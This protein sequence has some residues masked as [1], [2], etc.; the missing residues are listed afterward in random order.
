MGDPPGSP[1]L[2]AA[3]VP[4]MVSCVEFTPGRRTA[5][6]PCE[7]EARVLSCC[8]T[9]AVPTASRRHSPPYVPLGVRVSRLRCNGVVPTATA[10]VWQQFGSS[11]VCVC[12]MWQLLWF[13]WWMRWS[14]MR[15]CVCAGQPREFLLPAVAFSISLGVIT[16]RLT[17]SLSNRL[18]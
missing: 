13:E 6:W 4:I 14:M 8:C 9:A 3:A 12:C 2:A 15:V 1:A 10:G 16:T 17:I 5:A 7:A 11:L 18:A